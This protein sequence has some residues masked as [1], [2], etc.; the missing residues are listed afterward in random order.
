[1]IKMTK[2]YCAICNG[3]GFYEAPTMSGGYKSTA[4]DHV[5][6][7]NALNY[8]LKRAKEVYDIASKEYSYLL[9]CAK[10]AKDE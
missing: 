6:E 3:T 1:M 7:A 4:C 10:G 5:W 9:K 8:R 2:R